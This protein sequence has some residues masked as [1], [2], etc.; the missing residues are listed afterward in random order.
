MR[1]YQNA[2]VFA[3]VGNLALVGILGG[4][5]FSS[6]RQRTAEAALRET[7]A[8]SPNG[9]ESIRLSQLSRHRINQGLKLVPTIFKWI[10]RA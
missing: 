2:F 7:P 5:W 6:R 8:S 1:N 3:V 9:S 4:F 10:P